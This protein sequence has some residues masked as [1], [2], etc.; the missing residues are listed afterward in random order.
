MSKP[1]TDFSNSES[2][3]DNEII[4][5]RIIRDNSNKS[6][7]ISRDIK[8]QKVC[9]IDNLDDC[10][11]ELNPGAIWNAEVLVTR[12]RYQAVKLLSILRP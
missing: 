7:W 6:G 2:T 4:S 3:S 5:V 8:T 11:L 1:E 9:F 10:I 12:D